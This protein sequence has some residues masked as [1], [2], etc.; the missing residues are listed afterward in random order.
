MSNKSS[1]QLTISIAVNYKKMNS[2]HTS[3]DNSLST[4]YLVLRYFLQRCNTTKLILSSG[5]SLYDRS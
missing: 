2:K 4:L 3:T 5:K 1:E